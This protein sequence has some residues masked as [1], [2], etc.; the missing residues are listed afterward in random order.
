MES[1]MMG[2]FCFIELAII[3]YMSRAIGILD[4]YLG[5]WFGLRAFGRF[6]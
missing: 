3:P 6:L 4:M 1:V 5:V 2:G